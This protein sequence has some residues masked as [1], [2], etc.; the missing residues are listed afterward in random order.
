VRVLVVARTRMR[1]D[2]VCVGGLDL[3]SGANLRLLGKD[4]QNL[5]QD[6]PIRAGD[7]WEITGAPRGVVVPPHVEDFVVTSGRCTNHVADLR[8]AILNLAEPWNCDLDAVFN[9][10]LANTPSGTG[11][12]REG[13][14]LPPGSVGF[15][16]ART[17]IR[18]SKFEE[19]GRSY[20]VP[21]GKR[22]RKV[23][24]VG[25]DD[26]IPLVATG[27]LLRFSLARW[28]EFPPGVGEK[29]CYLQLSGWF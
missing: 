2:R 20:W 11:F 10:C 7:I 1:G 17:V 18:Q 6:H 27:S 14:P 4:E 22:I 24:Y 21:D 26:P 12:L 23:A 3:D 13:Q 5:A 28:K 16:I 15:W 29:R 19:S 9:G 8:S 25:M